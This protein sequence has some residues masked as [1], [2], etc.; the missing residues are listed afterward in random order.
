MNTKT[1]DSIPAIKT[2]PPTG[3]APPPVTAS[4][5]YPEDPDGSR[6]KIPS[7]CNEQASMLVVPASSLEQKPVDTVARPVYQG[8]ESLST[9]M[10]PSH[11]VQKAPVPLIAPPRLDDQAAALASALGRPNEDPRC[12][13]TTASWCSQEPLVSL[14]LAP[15]PEQQSAVPVT[16]PLS[17]EGEHPHHSQIPRCPEKSA[18]FTVTEPRHAPPTSNSLSSSMNGVAHCMQ[19]QQT[20]SGAAHCPI[21]SDMGHVNYDPARDA[22]GSIPLFGNMHN[23]AIYSP[24]PHLQILSGIHYP[25]TPSATP[26]ATWIPHNSCNWIDGS[27]N[28][29]AMNIF[30]ANWAT[31]DSGGVRNHGAA[32]SHANLAASLENGV[33]KSI[34]SVACFIEPKT[35][36]PQMSATT[37][38]SAAAGTAAAVAEHSK[39]VGRHTAV[40][41]SATA[42]SAVAAAST[43]GAAAVRAGV[44]GACHPWD[45][46][47][48]QLYP[49]SVPAWSYGGNNIGAY[50][51]P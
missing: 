11:P 51:H 3:D 47:A 38:A 10:A 5:S 39:S 35:S 22:L 29:M 30:D 49:S 50:V 24:P 4:S 37:V 20:V 44:H 21:S 8:E 34:P 42:V 23:T 48:G 41:A 18:Q 32:A 16:T 25:A 14:V 31:G 40:A 43:A 27:H 15:V 28:P 2:S 45:L 46:P 33:S 9:V 36:G 7:C 17:L 13:A 1:E 12:T 26:S 19:Q 6:R